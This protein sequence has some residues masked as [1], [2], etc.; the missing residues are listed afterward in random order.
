MKRWNLMR[1]VFVGCVFVLLV[2][3]V[4]ATVLSDVSGLGFDSIVAFGDSLMDNG[5][6]YAMTG[7]AMPPSP[8]YW[9]GRFSN[10]PVWVEYLADSMGLSGQLYDFAV[11]GS[12]TAN[13]LNDQIIPYTTSNP[14]SVTT[15][16]VLGAANNDFLWLNPADPTGWIA[17]AVGNISD[18][19]SALYADGAKHLLFANVPN[20]GLVPGVAPELRDAATAMAQAFNGEVENI[21]TQFEAATDMT[22]YRMDLF[23]MSTDV[24]RNP[25]QYG[26]IN[27]TDPYLPDA[28]GNAND[29]FFF[30]D[31]HPTTAVHA[32]MVPEPATL[33]MLMTGSCFVLRGRKNR[34]V[35]MR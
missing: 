20:Y 4:G 10:G 34:Q 15:L 6:L 13:V 24:I 31:V 32:L 17:P 3:P 18:S 12:T 21:L 22:F 14:G 8:P 9:E 5:N 29:Y 35:A 26:F 2:S 7:G 23:G 33:I 27:S 25:E 1:A 30:D 16:Y 11:G 19:I 28:I